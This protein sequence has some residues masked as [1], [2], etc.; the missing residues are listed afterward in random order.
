M[1]FMIIGIEQNS[2][3]F[4]YSTVSVLAAFF[5]VGMIKGK[6]VKKSMLH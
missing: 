6:I 5:L 2:E 1:I 4:V 3:A